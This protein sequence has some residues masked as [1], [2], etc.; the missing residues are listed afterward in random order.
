MMENIISPNL[1]DFLK[2]PLFVNGVVVINERVDLA[3]KK[4]LVSFS[5]WIL[6]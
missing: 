4:K 6:K 2:G 1:S 3:R 5:R